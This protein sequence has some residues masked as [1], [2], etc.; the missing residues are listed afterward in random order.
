MKNAAVLLQDDATTSYQRTTQHESASLNAVYMKAGVDFRFLKHTKLITLDSLV[1]S[2]NVLLRELPKANPFKHAAAQIPEAVESGGVAASE[3]TA[4]Q[5]SMSSRLHLFP[6]C[7]L[8]VIQSWENIP[9]KPSSE[10]GL[11]QQV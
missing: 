9:L 5:C 11:C 4:R 2:C 10:F 1:A 8:R 3:R 7:S 6:A